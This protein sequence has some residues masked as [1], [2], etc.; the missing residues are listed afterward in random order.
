VV[1]ELCDAAAKPL[2]GYAPS[3][4]FTGDDLR[5]VVTFQGKSDV[6]ALTGKPIT[7]RFH[8]KNAVLYSFAFRD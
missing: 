8:L 4:P 3:D 6:S 7:L 5:H 1:I 2:A